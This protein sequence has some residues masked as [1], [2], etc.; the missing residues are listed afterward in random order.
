VVVVI[1]VVVVVVV[2]AVVVVV[3]VVQWLSALTAKKGGLINRQT[4]QCHCFGV[5]ARV[6]VT[7]KT[8]VLRVS[9]NRAQ[10]TSAC[11]RQFQISAANMESLFFWDDLD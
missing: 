11:A 2:I 7:V 10:N 3:V 8:S 5:R 4:W 1:V 9:G 6:S